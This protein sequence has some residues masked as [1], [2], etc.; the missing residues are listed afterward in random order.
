MFSLFIDSNHANA[1]VNDSCNICKCWPDVPAFGVIALFR[2]PIQHVYLNGRFN[3]TNDET[4][5]NFVK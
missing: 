3:L 5:G 2:L 1:P 4:S